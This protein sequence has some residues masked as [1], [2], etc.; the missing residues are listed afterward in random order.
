MSRVFSRRK[1]L[2]LG[3]AVL[4]TPVLGRSAEAA[5]APILVELFTS[6]GCSSCP[7]ADRLAGEM[8]KNKQLIVVSLNVDYW[9]YLGWKDTLAKAEY[10]KRQMDYAHARGD[11]DVYTPQMVINGQRHAVGSRKS[12]VEAAISKVRPA[13]V[14]V[15]ISSDSKEIV[16]EIGAGEATDATLW[17]MSIAPEVS[18]D[19]ERGENTGATVT[20]H[21]VVRKLSPVGMWK[22]EAMKVRLPRASL[23]TENCKSCVAVLQDGNVGPVLGL[24]RHL[25]STT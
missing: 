10:T 15:S 25:F 2:G 24:A 11:G 13:Q 17:L 4:A 18:V 7:P 6:Q 5:A 1:A 14:P 9:D 19:I 12:D 20:Y 16:V 23:T 21:N 3:A 8:R 22:G